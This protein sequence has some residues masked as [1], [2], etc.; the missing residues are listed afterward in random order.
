MRKIIAAALMGTAIWSLG[1]AC[2]QQAAQASQAPVKTDKAKILGTWN[3]DVNTGDS[4][5]YLTLVMEDMDGK[6][7]GKISE[8][9]GM[10]TDAALANI[11]YSGDDFS[12]EISVPSPPDMAV[13]TWSIK[14]KV[15]DDTL[16]GSIANSDLG[17]S[18]DISGKRVKK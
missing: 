17:L 13:K 14:A 10:F 18:A 16:A 7:A 1:L 2:P 12:T 3:L 6:L 9:N 15:G 5:V 4:I 11:E 8:Q